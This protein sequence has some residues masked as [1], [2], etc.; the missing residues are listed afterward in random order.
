MV[1]QAS[2]FKCHFGTM[3]PR[4]LAFCERSEMGINVKAIG[5]TSAKN[6]NSS[7]KSFHLLLTYFLN[8]LFGELHYHKIIQN[9]YKYIHKDQRKQT[10]K[11][12]IINIYS[13]I[14]KNNIL[15]NNSRENTLGYY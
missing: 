7:L 6:T 14:L 12:K 9:F 4:S 5:M 13:H 11:H 10:F 1:I 3:V 8:K 2:E 15:R